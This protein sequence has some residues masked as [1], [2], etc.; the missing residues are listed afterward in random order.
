MTDPR[1]FKLS[2]WAQDLLRQLRNNLANREGEIVLLT[3]ENQRL[4]N[5]IEQRYGEPG[6]SDTNL[7]NEDTTASIPLGNG[8]TVWFGGVYEVHWSADTR[9]LLIESTHDMLIRPEH[10]NYI[11]ITEGTTE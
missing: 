8:P 1:E 4:R 6:D 5:V 2:I 11:A 9:E 3:E 10:V 7:V